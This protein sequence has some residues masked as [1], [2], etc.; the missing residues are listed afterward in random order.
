MANQQNCEMNLAMVTKRRALSL[1]PKCTRK[2]ALDGG[3]WLN[4][5]ISGWSIGRCQITSMPSF[6][7]SSRLISFSLNFCIFPDP[8]RGNA[9]MKNTYLGIL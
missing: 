9:S 7:Q 2:P 4:L 5:L 8:V 1:S 3:G 6:S